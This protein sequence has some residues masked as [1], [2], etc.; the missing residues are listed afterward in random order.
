MYNKEKKRRELHVDGK[1]TP[2]A[3]FR[4]NM[5]QY[6]FH[7][8]SHVTLDR[9]WA[10]AVGSRRL[11][12]R[13]QSKPSPPPPQWLRL[14]RP[15]KVHLG[16]QKF[17]T[18]ELRRYILNRPSSQDKTFHLPEQWKIYISEKGA[19][20][21]KEWALWQLW[22]EYFLCKKPRSTL[23]T[24]VFRRKYSWKCWICFQS[25]SF[26]NHQLCIYCYLSLTWSHVK[27]LW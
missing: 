25:P 10:A 17:R 20:L 2:N 19:C 14:F 8:K 4:E 16:G 12:D 18:V 15:M 24:N 21:E 6:H 3:R 23:N 27:F 11:I 7:H 22:Y 5:P 26:V 9:T 13:V 1:S